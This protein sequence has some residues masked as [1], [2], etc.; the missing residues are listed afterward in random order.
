VEL[1]RH[2]E[3]ICESRTYFVTTPEFAPIVKRQRDD[4]AQKG[5]VGRQRVF[6]ALLARFQE[7]AFLTP[8]TDITDYAPGPNAA[9]RQT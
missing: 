8:I 6:D 4:A 3:F 2:F 5:Q 9:P 1:D 7:D